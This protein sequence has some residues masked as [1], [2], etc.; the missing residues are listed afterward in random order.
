LAP[1]A[2]L[3]V[4]ETGPL[5]LPVGDWILTT[6]CADA[7][8]IRRAEQPDFR[9]GVN[10]FA[11]QLRA[12]DFVER[13][14]EALLA[15]GLPADALELEITENIVLRNERTIADHLSRLR[16]MNIGIAF[17]DFGTGYASLTLL[18]QLEITRLKIDRSFIRD[19]A[20]DQKDQGIVEAVI[21][22]ARGCDLDVIAEG[23]ETQT[24]A[25]YLRG[26]LSEG[27]G[28]LFGKPMPLT[29]LRQRLLAA[30]SERQTRAFAPV[31]KAM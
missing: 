1:A 31:R 29:D 10:L 9:I 15:S 18:K 24:Q 14:E 4:L 27:Q 8:A 30:S 22:M 13:V 7:M 23:I 5:A 12:P 25:A 20:S 16:R 17:D 2:F 21:R 28:Y 26:R 6:A 11:A 19:I 3:S